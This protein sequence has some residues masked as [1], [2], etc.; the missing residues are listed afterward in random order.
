MALPVDRRRQTRKRAGVARI[1]ERADISA[2][3][4]GVL[5]E[6]SNALNARFEP[7]L[8]GALNDLEQQLFKLAEQARNNAEQELAYASLREVKRG[9]ADIGP[10]FAAAIESDLASFDREPEPVPASSTGPK[11]ELMQEHV[12]EEDLALREIASRA[13]VRAS[14]QL[15]ELGHRFA[16]LAALPLFESERV[17]AGPQRVLQALRGAMAELDLP[18]AHR[19]LGWRLFEKRALGEATPFYAE[20]NQLLIARRILPNL[21]V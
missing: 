10:R 18:T 21:I 7:A 5:E 1:A 8:R 14:E 20:I 6:L 16:V 19:V 2:R 15:Y 17:P 12:F 13:E 4:R 11:L 9:R 3:V